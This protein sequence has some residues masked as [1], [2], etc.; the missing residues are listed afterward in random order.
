M[1]HIPPIRFALV[2]GEGPNP[3]TIEGE[4]DSITITLPTSYEMNTFMSLELSKAGGGIAP[5][6]SAAAAAA[7]PASKIASIE[8]VGVEQE[9]GL[10]FKPTT[11]GRCTIKISFDHS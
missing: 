2:A 9:S 7:E 3:L 8:L 4:E 1:P 10:V 6:H 11:V 5:V